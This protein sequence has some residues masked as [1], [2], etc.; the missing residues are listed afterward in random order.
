MATVS[1]TRPLRVAIYARVSTSDQRADLQ[2]DDLRQIAS[3]RGWQVVGEYVDQGVSGMKD[4]RPQLD[5]MMRRVHQGGIDIIGVWKLDRLA[6]SVRHLIITLDEL[7]AMK[8]EFF[9]AR[10]AIDTSTPAGRFCWT[11]IGAVGELEREL[12]VERTKA[13]LAAA[14]R[15]GKVLG[16]PRVLVD[17]ER[18]RQLRAAGKSVREIARIMKTAR[19]TVHRALIGGVPQSPSESASRGPQKT[20]TSGK[21]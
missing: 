13:G 16:R 5:A 8:V 15:R 12:I 9:S 18:V 14:R 17:L 10:D 20:G 2:V 1:G 19:S 4:S 11:V 6:R 21:R 7:R 3:Q